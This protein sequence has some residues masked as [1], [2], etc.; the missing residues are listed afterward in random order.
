MNLSDKA[1]QFSKSKY[2]LPA[3]FILGLFTVPYL[4]ILTAVVW[5]FYK[6]D[7]FTKKTKIITVLVPASLFI[8]LIILVVIGYARDVQPTL[9]LTTGT[10]ITTE[11]NKITIE[12]TYTP[13]DRKVW[14]NNE[15][16]KSSEGKFETTVDLKDGENVIRVSAGDYKRADEEII[17]VKNPKPTTIPAT[18]I[19]LNTA[20]PVPEA[21]QIVDEYYIISKVIDGDTYQVTKD[22]K[23]DTIRVIGINS[24]ET[25]DPRKPVECFGKEAS[26]RAKSVLTDKKVRLE[27]DDSQGNTDKY[28]RLLRYIFTEKGTDVGLWLIKDGYA[29]EYTYNIPYKYQSKYKDAQSQ[30]NSNKL[31][32]WAD[33]ACVTPTP[34]LKPTSEY[35]PPTN[36]PVKQQ[37]NNIAPPVENNSGGYGCDCSKTCSN[38]SCD[39]AYFQLNQCGCKERDGNGDGVPCESQCG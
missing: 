2:F 25:V 33:N 9:A 22:G 15:L 35:V 36:P 29:Y 27:A 32:L 8:L 5:W 17:V 21:T 26:A 38:M 19:P 37:Q 31:G 20:T 12:G 24:P 10:K 14:I 7:R 11:E 23:K 34:T 39:E 6:T 13:S 3:L 16:I 4:A 28:G 18:P 30:A 1:K